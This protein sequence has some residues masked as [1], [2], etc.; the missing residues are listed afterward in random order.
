MHLAISAPNKRP[1]RSHRVH[2]QTVALNQAKRNGLGHNV[3]QLLG[4]VQ[5]AW[6]AIPVLRALHE[7]FGAEGDGQVWL[8]REALSHAY[9]EPD[10]LRAD[11]RAI[12]DSLKSH[13]A[14]LP[15]LW[16]SPLDAP[17]HLSTDENR[18]A[19]VQ[20]VVDGVHALRDRMRQAWRGRQHA[21]A[22]YIE[23]TREYPP[24][25]DQP[26]GRG[27][28]EGV[29]SV[30]DEV[31]N[32][33]PNAVQRKPA[34][35]EF[36]PDSATIVAPIPTVGGVARTPHPQG[37]GH[38][39]QLYSAMSPTSPMLYHLPHSLPDT[40]VAL[41]A[42]GMA[43]PVLWNCSTEMRADL[44]L[45]SEPLVRAQQAVKDLRRLEASIQIDWRES[46]LLLANYIELTGDYPTW[47]IPPGSDDVGVCECSVLWSHSGERRL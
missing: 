38:L 19:L 39:Q 24:F 13:G 43:L 9:P 21:V 10:T 22:D 35:Q 31:G 8:Y 2:D 25:I 14:S 7:G 6:D 34:E 17:K 11:L 28:A 30:Y 47:H 4:P 1:R 15:I 27:L 40:L 44:E 26:L 5:P 16:D 37:T 12:V 23:A 33:F 36:H 20:K 32:R 18:E 45:E 42:G 3:P 41:R 29:F 46:Q